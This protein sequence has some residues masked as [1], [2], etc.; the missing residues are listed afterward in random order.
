MTLALWIMNMEGGGSMSEDG[1]ADLFNL[2]FSHLSNRKD[3][4]QNG[5]HD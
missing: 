5:E 2:T 1:L 3:H 4:P